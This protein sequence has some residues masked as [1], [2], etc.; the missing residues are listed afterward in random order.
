MTG[1]SCG[2][3]LVVIV[4]Q[5]SGAAMNTPGSRERR[6]KWNQRYSAREPVWSRGPN[7]NL[8]AEIQDLPPGR[9]LDLGTGE[10]RHAIW[11]ASNNWQVTA[12]DFA[13]VGLARGKDAAAAL[14]LD[15]NW[16]CADVNSYAIPSDAFDLVIILYLH[17]PANELNALIQKAVAGLSHNGHFLYIGHDL[18][19]IEKGQGGPQDPAVL[20]HPE[21]IVAELP[22]FNILT[23]QVRQREIEDEPGHGQAISGIALDAV[24]HGIKSAQPN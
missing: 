20:C 7:L 18:S 13:E 2:N 24:V 19:N 11:L 6:D 16:V 3:Q 4:R 14:D 22:G 1:P 8:V 12:V 10:G 23:A 17:I 15:I 9:V 21:D 5:Q